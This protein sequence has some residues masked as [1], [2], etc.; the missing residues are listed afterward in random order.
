M[1]F[2]QRSYL[3]NRSKEAALDLF[4]LNVKMGSMDSA[5]GIYNI[6]YNSLTPSQNFEC[7]VQMGD[8]NSAFKQAELQND[9]LSEVFCLGYLRYF[10]QV[11]HFVK[12]YES[13]TDEQKRMTNVWFAVAF[14]SA[15]DRQE[16]DHFLAQFEDRTFQEV[17]I[18]AFLY[19]KYGQYDLAEEY[20]EKV[21]NQLVKF[22]K[23]FNGSDE[24][25]ASKILIASHQLNKLNECLQVRRGTLKDIME[26]FQHDTY[27]WIITAEIRK[28]VLNQ[29]ENLS[30]FV[31]MAKVFRKERSW[32]LTS[33]NFMKLFGDTIKP[34]IFVERLKMK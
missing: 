26:N 33:Y 31:K 27:S 7:N 2:L 15:N 30:S 20:I 21:F 24:R 4:N 17:F 25:Q 10:D 18:K 32:R 1:Y 11:T 5:K 12:D 28:L 6:M 9:K 14:Y 8:W 16:V 13:F 3:S 34:S 23:F 19:I 22:K 29:S